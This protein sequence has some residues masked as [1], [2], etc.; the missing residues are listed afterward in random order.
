MIDVEAVKRTHE[1]FLTAHKSMVSRVGAAAGARGV[2][3]VWANP[4]FTPRTGKLQKGT[5]A[6]TLSRVNGV[7]VR[8]VNRRGYASY[9]EHGTRPHDIVAKNGGMLRFYW[10][11]G[12]GNVAFRKVRHPGTKATH[13]LSRAR[14][15]AYEW[16]GVALR[17]EMASVARRF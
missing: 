17:R 4:G 13:F 8:L 7:M 2:S 10:A 12:G 3:F 11:K 1:Q 6:K 9:V 16:A 5:S 15:N 14:D